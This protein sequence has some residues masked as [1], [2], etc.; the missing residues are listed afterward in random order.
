MSRP[1]VHM[2]RLY[3]ATMIFLATTVPVSYVP[4]PLYASYYDCVVAHKHEIP[5][6]PYCCL[7]IVLLI[8]PALVK[9]SSF[10]FPRL[11]GFGF[12][13]CIIKSPRC[14]QWL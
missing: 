11:S 10:R 2:Y 6:F 8:Y 3:L 7:S 5:N 9:S 1:G 13:F 14:I 4:F 12:C